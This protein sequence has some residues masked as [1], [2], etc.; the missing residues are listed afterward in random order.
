MQTTLFQWS[1]D[2]TGWTDDAEVFLHA[3]APAVLPFSCNFASVLGEQG[4]PWG[5]VAKTTVGTFRA[6][7]P[8]E[9]RF[10]GSNTLSHDNNTSEVGWDLAVEISPR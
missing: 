2:V 7:K 5:L 4:H 10:A 9:V 1:V 6:G 8:F 3:E